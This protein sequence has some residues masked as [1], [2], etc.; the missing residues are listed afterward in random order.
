MVRGKP[1][2]DR[3]TK[4][5]ARA[6]GFLDLASGDTLDAV[7]ERYGVP[8]S[9]VQAWAKKVKERMGATPA[10]IRGNKFDEAVQDAATA[11]MA[12]LR[13]QSELIGDKTWVTNMTAKE[14][15]AEAVAR[16]TDA[17]GDRIIV[18]VQFAQRKPPQQLP[19]AEP[20]AIEA[21]IVDAA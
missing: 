5:E 21:E 17:I 4:A 8:R 2:G 16:F 18:T 1:K 14:G 12:A 10:E 11:F 15:G 19:E 3:Q 13:S 6:E 7:A 20:L 9:T